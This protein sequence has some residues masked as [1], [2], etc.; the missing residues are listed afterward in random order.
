MPYRLMNEYTVAVLGYD[1]VGDEDVMDPLGRGPAVWLQQLDPRKPL[2]H[3][4]HVDISVPHDADEPASRRHSPPAVAWR[5]IRTRPSGGRSP[6]RWA[7]RSTSRPGP[8]TTDGSCRPPPGLSR[9][10]E[11]LRRS[12]GARRGE[13]RAIAR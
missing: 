1:A 12:G 4:T 3:A 7:T 11:V 9:G 2:R 10:P 8:I 5:T 13:I 6:I